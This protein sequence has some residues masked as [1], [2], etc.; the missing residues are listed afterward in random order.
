MERILVPVYGS[1]FAEGAIGLAGPL[2]ARRYHQW[3]VSQVDEIRYEWHSDWVV[4]A[5][6]HILGEEGGGK[7]RRLRPQAVASVQEEIP[8]ALEESGVTPHQMSVFSLAPH[9][10]IGRSAC[11]RSGE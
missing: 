11:L 8:G 5:A 7:D 2:A 4:H 9:E 3:V 6:I 10:V 1:E